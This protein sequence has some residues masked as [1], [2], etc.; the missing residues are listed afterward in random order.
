MKKHATI[1]DISNTLLREKIES[2]LK[3]K[4]DATKQELAESLGLS[5]TSLHYL[6]K[7]LSIRLPRPQRNRLKAPQINSRA[8]QVLGYLMN[9]PHTTLQHVADQF[10]CTREYVS[11][12]ETKARV[13]GILK[14]APSDQS[15]AA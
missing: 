6:L 8:F 4:P 14:P 7:R 5:Y 11:Q 2:I 3:E 15:L 9:N 1:T 13:A 12:I 10:R